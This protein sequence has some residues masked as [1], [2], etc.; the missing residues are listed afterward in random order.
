VEVVR[1]G[2]DFQPPRDRG[3]L[4]RRGERF[5][6]LTPGEFLFLYV[7]DHAWEKNLGFL[8]QC[9][10]HLKRRGFRFQAVFV[11]GGYAA[12]PLRL[13]A[14]RVGLGGAAKFVGVLGDRGM[15]AACYARA[16]CFVFPSLYDTCG[17]VVREAAAF[18][19][20]SV[21]LESSAASEE[22]VDG[23]NGFAAGHSVEEYT[24]KLA[25]L[26]ERP[27][28]LR[29]TGAGARDTLCRSW[30]EAVREVGERYLDI[31]G[32]TRPTG[33]VFRKEFMV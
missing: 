2:I 4:Q 5:L 11:G 31:L 7:G 8:L 26:M 24:G 17:L 20:P 10:A 1:H 9:L 21:V 32:R 23:A 30:R 12:R 3:A 16:D 28:L 15:L 22:I 18:S 6:S 25:M 33:R 27:E 19:L 14:S 29:R 13:M